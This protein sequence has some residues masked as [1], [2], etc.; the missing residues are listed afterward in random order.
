MKRLNRIL[1]ITLVVAMTLLTL[2]ACNTGDD[3]SGMSAYEIAVKNGYEG[4][5]TEWLQSL[6][7]TNTVEKN[8]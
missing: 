1:I 6:H 3:S 7:T 2:A 5:E 8:H 4:S